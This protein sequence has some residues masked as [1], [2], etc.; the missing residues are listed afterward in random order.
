MLSTESYIPQEFSKYKI[1]IMVILLESLFGL[2]AIISNSEII[3]SI[4]VLSLL[5][6][7]CLLDSKLIPPVLIIYIFTSLY[8]TYPDLGFYRYDLGGRNLYTFELLLIILFIWILIKE[9]SQNFPTF[10]KLVLLDYLIIIWIAITSIAI[11]RGVLAGRNISDIVFETRFLVFLFGY[12]IFS[13]LLEK[14]EVLNLILYGLLIS[15]IIIFCYTIINLVDHNF[16]IRI[17]GQTRLISGEQGF[18]VGFLAIISLCFALYDKNKNYILMAAFFVCVIMLV[19]SYQRS[20]YMQFFASFIILA[21]FIEKGK[22]KFFIWTVVLSACFVM[23]IFTLSLL[24]NFKLD[25]MV[26]A[27]SE[28]TLSIKVETNDPSVLGRYIEYG[29]S[30]IHIKSEPV[31]GTGMG[32]VLKFLSPT[33]FGPVPTVRIVP[34]NELEWMALKTGIPNTLLFCGIIFYSIYSGKRI[35]K[36]LTDPKEKAFLLA[37]ISTLTGIIIRAQFEDSF[38]KHRIG[39]ALWILLGTVAFFN[40]REKISVNEKK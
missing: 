37:V 36:K 31:L 21:I 1:L 40:R 30:Y 7:L 16:I 17:G 33:D 9:I 2:A 20:S 28:R 23:I 27:F 35:Y 34:H 4:I 5:I 24:F 15:G 14:K 25:S 18:I 22:K 29:L 32:L 6:T 3:A 8:T 19:I 38:H 11:I 12:Y 39:F 10:K 13:V 26:N